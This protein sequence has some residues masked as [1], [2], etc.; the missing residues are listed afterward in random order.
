[1]MIGTIITISANVNVIY[2]CIIRL[3]RNIRSRNFKL[4]KP[5]LLDQHGLPH[6]SI[7]LNRPY[8]VTTKTQTVTITSR[9]LFEDTQLK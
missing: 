7:T 2:A 4:W 3:T 5:T 6:L 1:M 8:R 9:L